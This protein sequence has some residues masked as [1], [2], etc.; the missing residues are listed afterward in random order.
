MQAKAV[1]ISYGLWMSRK[2][3]G[4]FYL[5]EQYCTSPNRNNTHIAMLSTNGID[6]V[7]MYKY[8]TEMGYNS[9]LEE[10][11]VV[12][13]SDGGGNLRFCRESLE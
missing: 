5:T 10:N 6:G 2:V 9:V 8:V 1:L 3:D 12:I 7:S 11:I 13:T 4:I